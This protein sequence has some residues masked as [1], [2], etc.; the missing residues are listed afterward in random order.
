MTENRRKELQK[1][2]FLYCAVN[3]MK[4]PRQYSIKELRRECQGIPDIVV[5]TKAGEFSRVFSIYFTWLFLRLKMT[6]NQLTFWG[7]TLYIFGAV[8]FAFGTQQLAF[9]A[10][11]FM[12]LATLIDA[13][14]GE[15]A[16]FWGKKG[17]YGASYVEPLSHDIMYGLMFMPIA[18][19][20]FLKTGEPLFLVAG[21]MA[22][23][24]KLLFRI[25]QVR[26]FYGV[27]KNL[28]A[29]RHTDTTKKL[30]E[31]KRGHLI[32]W[33]YRNIATSS[34][35]HI[36]LLIAIIFYRL[37]IFIAVY[38]LIFFILWLGLFVRQIRRFGG[39]TG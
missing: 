12:I 30:I 38:A 16:R 35:L 33:F 29:N 26:F 7:S 19:G 23:I 27:Q 3:K 4:V 13:S 2:C 9:L 25:T 20:A 21:A 24:F 37:D 28:E 1:H 17:G 8:F 11:A 31:T 15:V 36:F 5:Q 18:Y 6:P 22:T 32:Y 10:F 39:I 14:D 34:G